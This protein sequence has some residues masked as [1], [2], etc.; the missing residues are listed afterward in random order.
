MNKY[1]YEITKTI[2]VE[3][4]V[5]NLDAAFKRVYSGLEDNEFDSRFLH[6]HPVVCLVDYKEG[7]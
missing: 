5:E 3:V 1:S 7:E 2:F 6:S 4:E